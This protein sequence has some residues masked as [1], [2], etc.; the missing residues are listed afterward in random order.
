MDDFLSKKFNNFVHLEQFDSA[1]QVIQQAISLNYPSELIN[2]WKHRLN[3]LEKIDRHPL[4]FSSETIKASINISCQIGPDLRQVFGSKIKHYYNKDNKIVNISCQ[5]TEFVFS[6]LDL[7]VGKILIPDI[8]SRNPLDNLIAYTVNKYISDCPDVIKAVNDGFALSAV[9]HFLRLGFFEI[10]DG[11]R[12]SSIHFSRDMKKRCGKMLYVVDDYYKLSDQEIDDLHSLHLGVF[13]ADILSVNDLCIYNSI[14]RFRV[15]AETYFYQNISEVTN[16]CILLGNSVVTKSAIKWICDIKLADKSAIF[17]FAN[18]DG[19]FHSAA[20]MS[21]VN[22][23]ISEVANG[24]IIVNS[25]EVLSVFNELK[26]YSSAYGFF[27]ALIFRLYGSGVKFILKHEIL[28][29]RRNDV[30]VNATQITLDTY[31]SPFYWHLS[32]NN[33]NKILLSSIRRDF[34]MTWSDYISTKNLK[35]GAIFDYSA[36]CVNYDKCIVTF[37]PLHAVSIAILIPFKDK[38]NLLED[39]IASLVSKA[40]NINFRIYAIDNN[41]CE[42]ETFDGLSILEKKYPDQF[43]VF[44]APGEFNYSKINND[45]AAYAQED[46]ILFL[47]N[48]ILFETDWTLSTL[49]KSH[50]FHNAIITGARLLYPSG[51]IQHNGIATTSLKHIAVYSPFS[52]LTSRANGINL[53]SNADSHPWDYTHECSAVTAACMLIKKSDFESIGG[54]DE[55]LKVGYNDI[56]LCFRAKE[57]YPSRPI[58]CCNE[59]T[60]I[61]LES[62]SRG[63]DNDKFR[64]AR[65]DKERYSLVNRHHSI[66]N[67]PDKHLSIDNPTNDIYKALKNML[68]R[69]HEYATPSGEA[70]SLDKLYHKSVFVE[71]KKDFACIFVHY[72]K[73]ALITKEC[74]HHIEKL[75]EYC[76]VYFVSSSEKLDSKPFEIQKIVPLCKQ[77]LIRENSGYDFG[78]WSHVIRENYNHLCSYK[79]VLLC[80]DSNW[81]P[82]GDFSDTFEKINKFASSADFFGL[83]SSITPSWHL[84]SFFILYTQSLFSS[85]LFKQHWFNICALKSK[86][87]IVMNYEVQW[88]MCLKRLGFKGISLYG[89]DFSLAENCTHIHWDKL[90]KSNY[91]YLKKELVRDN[92]LMINLKN[93]PD[94]ISSYDE[95]WTQHILEYLS[96]YGKQASDLSTFLSDSHEL[97]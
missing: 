14:G 50:Y 6:N 72:D 41:S 3:Q 43:V 61:H 40:E 38:I 47:N 82:M 63:L 87:D 84:Q 75:G 29:K 51:K 74:L 34:L 15:D 2:L 48:D 65:L 68:K 88:S 19:V 53:A 60:I 21:L 44:N 20:E 49:L 28:S 25:I 17:G 30:S 94:I 62:E 18:N 70:I 58:I 7:Q 26:K 97:D 95:N 59:A 93:L 81:G 22:L 27:H 52:G 92:P 83:T 96:R 11:K 79:G 71:N 86:Y 45:A 32:D 31:W 54:F 46:Y 64:R 16:L 10:L 33:E 56:D 57:V 73:D 55:K 39:C 76:D 36:L 85:S 42:A 66:F 24:C 12:S 69:Q 90:L 5:I 4:D 91:P 8:T 89:D 9:D 13:S 77:I 37:N 67:S 1:C 23:S 35:Q 80:N 78:C